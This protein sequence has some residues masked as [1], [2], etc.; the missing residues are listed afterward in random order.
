MKKILASLVTQESPAFRRGEMST[1][2]FKNM[3]KVLAAVTIIF[4]I[5]LAVIGHLEL[6]PAVLIGY[7]LAAA[8]II[9]TAARLS[10]VIGLSQE[11]AKRRM[12]FGLILR[13]A[14][15]LIVLLVSLKISKLI[16]F[17]MA[18]GFF[19]FYVVAYLGLIITSYNSSFLDS[20]DTD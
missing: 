12:L 5:N 9:S 19:A 18:A 4:V 16:F 14:M 17:S 3:R 11:K 13:M 20:N 7:I 6:L 2:S 15:F 1:V 10:S 8:Y